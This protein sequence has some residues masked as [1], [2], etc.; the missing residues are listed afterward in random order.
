MR[1]IIATAVSAALLC[2]AAAAAKDLT[3]V[4]GAF[5]FNATDYYYP[6]FYD[7]AGFRGE[8][9]YF[10]WNE[11]H[12][13]RAQFY[14]YPGD[15]NIFETV[16]EYDFNWELNG[17]G[18]HIGLVPTGGL[19]IAKFQYPAPY[20]PTVTHQYVPWLRGGGEASVAHGLVGPV[21]LRGAFRF[22]A[23]YQFTQNYGAFE[24]DKGGD[25]LELLYAPY[26]E[27]AIRLDD[28]WR[29]IGRGGVEV[30]GYYDTVFLTPDE[31]NRP[32]GEVGFE[33]SW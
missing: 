18:F 25:P 1:T 7:E 6:N 33:H 16:F 27:V 11:R 23:L 13:L 22:R 31:K 12:G 20:Y 5:K 29:M 19:G 21:D 2:G 15:D 9:Y 3:F 26:G 14:G 17:A 30:G 4:G 8:L 32:Y 28:G 10:P 24:K